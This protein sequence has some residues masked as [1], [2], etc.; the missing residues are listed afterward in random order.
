MN[1]FNKSVSYSDLIR[2]FFA[3]KPKEV[4]GVANTSQTYYRQYLLKKIL[5]RFEFK[6][7]PEKWELDYFLWHLFVDGAICITDTEVGIIPQK[8]GLTGIGI[9]EQPIECIIASPVL[10]SFRRTIGED[11]EIIKLQ[12]DYQG[13]NWILDRYSALL[14]MCDSSIAVNLMNTK[15][16]YI[17]KC[18]NKGQSETIKAMYDEITCGKP[19]T[20]IGETAFD[21][22]S[23][24]IMPAKQNFIADDVQLL[25][26]KIL[27]EFLTDIGINNTNLDK[28][29]RLTDDEV[30][31]NND[32]VKANVQHWLDNI[33]E[34]L[35]RVNDMYSLD[36]DVDLRE[37]GGSINES[38]QLI[39]MV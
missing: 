27:N 8:C 21:K 31:A 4:D 2:N 35:T 18:A 39:T 1:R 22:E 6:N 20:F 36:L 32:E 5:S 37:F 9:Y 38:E 10:G 30:N 12:Y 16:T 11:C 19:A 24:Y 29:E 14:A 23:I 17:F 28:R 33:K 7:I 25:K 15:A 34:G 26:R 3:R 13:V